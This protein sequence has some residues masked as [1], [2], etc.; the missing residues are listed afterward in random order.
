MILVTGGAGY[1]GSHMVRMLVRH[2]F[3][4]VVIDSMEF[5][6]KQAI[7][8][9]VP[10]IT[11]NVGDEHVLKKLFSQFPID[12]VIHFAGYIS[13]EESVKDP[14]KYMYNNLIRP[15]TLL[16]VMKKN[17]VKCIIFSSTAAVYGNPIQVPIPERHPKNPT[18]PYGLSKWAFEEF[19]RVQE[20]TSGIRSI[21][22][23]Y[24]NACG[25]SLDGLHGEAH[26]PETHIIPLAIAA[27][28]GKRKEFYLYGTTYPT[29]DG[30]CVR[31]YIHI[32]DLCTAH[33]V[34]LE[35][36]KSGHATDIY[37]IGTGYGNTNREVIEA[38]RTISGSNFPLIEKEKRAG[39][40]NELV[41]DVSKL[42]RELGWKPKYSD[43]RTIVESAWKW[44]KNHPEGYA[45]RD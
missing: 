30:T 16:E 33:M 5:G 40:P 3:E 42:T 11:G 25:A 13:V 15:A 37:N 1:I 41:A 43:L 18:S 8:A 2:G 24:F 23:R 31:D 29:K 17:G 7:P 28:L 6:H 45:H 20:K 21:C 34:A 39:D 27:A 10:L 38:V 9:E 44:H 4:P 12:S 19:L 26:I 22:L 32:E 14:R 35:A 36:L